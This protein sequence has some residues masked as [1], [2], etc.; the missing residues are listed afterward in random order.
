[1]GKGA[2][3]P[4]RVKTAQ[5]VIRE[6]TSLHTMCSKVHEEGSQKQT[7]QRRE[8]T[9]DSMFGLAHLTSAATAVLLHQYTKRSSH[10]K[11]GGAVWGGFD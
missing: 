10:R 5:N 2:K 6:Q 11:E 1:L 4:C 7:V 3:D 8:K 9:R